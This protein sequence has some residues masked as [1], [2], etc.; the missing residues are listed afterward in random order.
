MNLIQMLRRRV[1]LQPG[2]PALIDHSLTRDRVI[3][4]SVLNR[5]VDFISVRLREE[6][7]QPGDR[8]VLL[9]E[10]SQEFYGVFLA[11]L[12][13]GAVPLLH[14]E[15][16]SRQEINT[17]L[18]VIRPEACIL[19]QANRLELQL[20]PNLRRI[21]KKIF[22][23]TIRFHTR[24][25]RLGKIGAIEEV[26]ASVH[27]LLSLGKGPDGALT[28]SGWTQKQLAETVQQ[29]ISN[30]KLKAGEI[31]LCNRALHLLANLAAGLTSIVPASVGCLSRTRLL[32]QINRFKPTRT[33]ASASALAHLLRKDSSPLHKVFILDAPL[34][35]STVEFF[36]SHTQHANIELIFE[37]HV[38]LAGAGLQEH[39]VKGTSVWVGNF[40]TDVAFQVAHTDDLDPVHALDSLQSLIAAPNESGELIVS[41]D[42]L[43]DPL[44]LAGELDSGKIVRLSQGGTTWIRTGVRGHL[45]H[46]RRFWTPPRAGAPSFPIV[47]E[48][49]AP[50][51]PGN[52]R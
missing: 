45:D 26:D 10:P 18:R 46:E 12:Q 11:L 42:F 8:V 6:K 34:E 38:P 29:L 9:L 43:P 51:Q 40:F 44:G 31:D 5:F 35:Q 22:V 41:A 28:V 24:W 36:S 7:I 48:L 20:N 37:R 52:G 49:A 30:L 50:D 47:S 13:I 39:K 15:G 27:A 2:V 3:S 21:P 17:W 19:S 33:S 25:L 1:E 4:F 23:N 14:E 16:L 32:R